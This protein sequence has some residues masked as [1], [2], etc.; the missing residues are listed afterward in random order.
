MIKFHNYSKEGTEQIYMCER[1]G[2]NC[3][4][5]TVR[6]QIHKIYI[7]TPE[8]GIPT[9]YICSNNG[10]QEVLSYYLYKL[11]NILK[12]SLKN[13]YVFLKLHFGNLFCVTKARSLGMKVCISLLS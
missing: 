10:Q 8:P 7:N 4:I 12:M 6:F 2:P 3:K 9:D 1:N 13:Q 11:N 5:H